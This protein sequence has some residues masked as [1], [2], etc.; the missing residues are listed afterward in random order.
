MS[1]NKTKILMIDKSSMNIVNQIEIPSPDDA[2][3]KAIALNNNEGAIGNAEGTISFKIATTKSI[4]PNINDEEFCIV[5]REKLNIAEQHKYQNIATFIGKDIGEPSSY[6]S[7][8]E[9]PM[10]ENKTFIELKGKNG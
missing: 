2:T 6:K 9:I 4:V 8:P 3:I 1:F 10:Q 5:I 7:N